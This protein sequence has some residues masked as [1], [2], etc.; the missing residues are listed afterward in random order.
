MATAGSLRPV[1]ANTRDGVDTRNKD[2]TTRSGGG[3]REYDGS[4][5]ALEFDA[6]LET[7]PHIRLDLVAPTGVEVEGA[8]IWG[9]WGRY[10]TLSQRRIEGEE[11]TFRYVSYETQLD[12]AEE[13]LMRCVPEVRQMDMFYLNELNRAITSLGWVIYRARRDLLSAPF[14]LDFHKTV[15]LSRMGDVEKAE[16]TRM[17]AAIRRIQAWVRERT[18]MTPPICV[19]C[20]WSCAMEGGDMKCEWCCGEEEREERPDCGCGSGDPVYIDDLCAD[21]Y[22]EEDAREKRARRALRPPPPIRIPI[23]DLE[24]ELDDDDSHMFER[25]G[26]APRVY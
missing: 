10:I 1:T 18:L 11:E 13:G 25:E 4:N 15:V 7:L 17:D 19:A 9:A 26:W 16:D 8:P 2:L 12:R 20:G 3:D 6:W 22:W 24:E 14:M 5:A 23:C 21:C